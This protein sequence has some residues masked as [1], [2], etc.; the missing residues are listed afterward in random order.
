VA[1][2]QPPG[3]DIAVAGTPL[4]LVDDEGRRA[5]PSKDISPIAAGFELLALFAEGAVAL[6][7]GGKVEVLRPAGLH[8]RPTQIVVIKSSCRPSRGTRAI[9]VIA[10][11]P[12]N[13]TACS[14]VADHPGGTQNPSSSHRR[15]TRE[16]HSCQEVVIK[17]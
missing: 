16:P 9:L 14:S 3:I 6:E 15:V 2:L 13:G 10:S 12:S 8:H 1:D 17:R 7:G 4:R 5:A 11:I